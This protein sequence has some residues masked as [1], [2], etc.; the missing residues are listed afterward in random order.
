MTSTINNAFQVVVLAALLSLCT[1]PSTALAR[2]W[3]PLFPRIRAFDNNTGHYCTDIPTPDRWS[4]REQ[5]IW[6]KCDEPWMIEGGWCR[7]TCGTG[8]ALQSSSW[9]NGDG[10]EQY[11]D[12]EE[13]S[14]GGDESKMGD[15]TTN[16]ISSSP[17]SSKPETA[18]TASTEVEL[19]TDETFCF[20][21][22]ATGPCR[23]A[24]PRWMYNIKSQTC[25]P[26]IYGGCEG[27]ENNF[28]SFDECVAAAVEYCGMPPLKRPEPVNLQTP[29]RKTMI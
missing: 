14:Q 27:N 19:V 17:S 3:E 26:F 13:G 21:N 8:G 4:C 18:S 29:R 5:K 16:N 20:Q 28:V 11:A 7:C 22:A 24:F 6:G 10:V 9:M 12:D 15:N 23:A 1:Q 25:Q 2:L